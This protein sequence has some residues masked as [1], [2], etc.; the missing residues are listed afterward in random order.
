MPIAS[1]TRSPVRTHVLPRAETRAFLDR[2]VSAYTKTTPLNLGSHREPLLIQ[3][4]RT[5]F[6]GLTLRRLHGLIPARLGTP[7][8]A[9]RRGQRGDPGR[10]E[11][12]REGRP[13]ST[14]ALA[15][16]ESLTGRGQAIGQ[17]R[18][19]LRIAWHR[20]SAWRPAPRPPCKACAT[21]FGIIQCRSRPRA[22]SPA[23]CDDRRVPIVVP[24]APTGRTTRNIGRLP[25]GQSHVI[26]TEGGLESQ[27]SRAPTAR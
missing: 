14:S 11:K 12:R 10:A 8:C 7:L 27:R 9:T 5:S 6:P 3:R 23:G 25:Y 20:Q 21:R 18:M 2:A 4:Q 26:V 13:F 15:F 1:D 24:P 22:W 17:M 19:V 16:S